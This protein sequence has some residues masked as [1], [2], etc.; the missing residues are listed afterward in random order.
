[1]LVFSG[2]RLISRRSRSILASGCGFGL[3]GG[4]RGRGCVRRGGVSNTEH[5]WAVIT[6]VDFIA[7]DTITHILDQPLGNNKVVKSP[8]TK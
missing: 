1:M 7:D 5:K 2:L 4:V 8:V 6:A 3:G